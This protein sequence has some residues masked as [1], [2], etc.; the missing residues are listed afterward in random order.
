MMWLLTFIKVTFSRAKE[1]P[2]ESLS[3]IF[4]V[5]YDEA[6]GNNHAWLVRKSAKVAMMASQS[7]QKFV[8]VILK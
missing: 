4:S 7:K 1:N 5:A 3:S 8:E 2:N 6:F